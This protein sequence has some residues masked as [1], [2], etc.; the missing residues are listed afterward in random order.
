MLK[1]G[2]RNKEITNVT[3]TIRE[4]TLR[5]IIKIIR[6]LY[7]FS[8]SPVC[9]MGNIYSLSLLLRAISLRLS[10]GGSELLY[11]EYRFNFRSIFISPDTAIYE[12]TESPCNSRSSF[13][14]FFF[15]IKGH[16]EM[17]EGFFSLKRK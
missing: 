4:K 1:S 15:S 7:F 5:I 16:R 3:N 9:V 2:E 13:L 8:L 11:R 12:T 14:F 10:I 17:C 6:I